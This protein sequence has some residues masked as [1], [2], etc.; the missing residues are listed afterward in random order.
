MRLPG[1]AHEVEPVRS[2]EDLRAGQAV[3]G[4]PC[5][6]CG[7]GHWVFLVREVRDPGLGQVWHTTDAEC[8]DPDLGFKDPV[9]T[10]TRRC[11]AGGRIYRIVDPDADRA[12]V[13]QR[14]RGDEEARGGDRRPAGRSAQVAGAAGAETGTTRS[15]SGHRSASAASRVE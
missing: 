14:D 10:I 11:V 12:Q 1:C 15:A 6:A 9:N 4:W 7:S 5:D 13:R 8:G 2:F 3:Y